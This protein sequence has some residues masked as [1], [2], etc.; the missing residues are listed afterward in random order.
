MPYH[1]L[2]IYHTEIKVNKIYYN[3]EGF[4]RILLEDITMYF[5]CKLL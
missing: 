3:S 5:N 1:S 4:L 2:I